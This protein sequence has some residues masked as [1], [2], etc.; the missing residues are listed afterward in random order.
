MIALRLPDVDAAAFDLD[1][2]LFDHPHAAAEGARVV[3]ASR[4]LEPSDAHVEL[5]FAAEARH[6]GRWLTGELSWDEQRRERVRDVFANTGLPRPSDAEADAVFDD[7]RVAYRAHW[8]AYADVVETLE[9]LR[10]QGVRIGVLTNG[11]LWQQQ[12]KLD[13]TGLAPLV[14]VVCAADEIGAP[15]PER[16]A[17]DAVVAALDVPREKVVF[18][19]DDAHADLAGAQGAGIRAALV[20][21]R[22]RGVAELPSALR[23]AAASRIAAGESVL[24]AVAG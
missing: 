4:G 24:G 8:R 16:A 20:R 12:E 2:T 23:R 22:E 6:F 15:K 18:I 7:F 14:D 13:L 19:G 17:F 21:S 3:L 11:P 9:R 10:E 5:W 1:G